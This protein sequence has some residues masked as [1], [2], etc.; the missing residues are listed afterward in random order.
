MVLRIAHQLLGEQ[1]QA[2]RFTVDMPLL[3]AF[4]AH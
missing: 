1:P 4:V 2:L 3:V